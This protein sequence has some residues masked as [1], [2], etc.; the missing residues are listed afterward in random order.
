MGFYQQEL[1]LKQYYHECYSINSS[2]QYQAVLLIGHQFS[3]QHITSLMPSPEVAGSAVDDI[4]AS[5]DSRL[6]RTFPAALAELPDLL[7]G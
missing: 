6:R 1:I 3:A 2:A 4:A 5:L 7:A